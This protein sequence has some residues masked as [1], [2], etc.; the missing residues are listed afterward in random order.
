MSKELVQR[1]KEQ[2]KASKDLIQVGMQQLQRGLSYMLVNVGFCWFQTMKKMESTQEEFEKEKKA[3]EELKTQ[4]ESVKKQLEQ[5]EKV[6]FNDQALHFHHFSIACLACVTGGGLRE[7]TGEEGNQGPPSLPFPPRFTTQAHYSF[8]QSFFV[9]FSRLLIDP[10]IQFNP[11]QILHPFILFSSIHSPI[12][13]RE[14]SFHCLVLQSA[15]QQSMMSLEIAEYERTLESLQSKLDERVQQLQ[16][17]QDE[18]D[19]QEKRV[20]DYKMQVGENVV[21]VFL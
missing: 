17:A 12:H 20:E 21:Y 11:S 6:H 16:D 4:L 2:E 3:H 1:E 19:R 5:A 14:G 9:L 10:C 13:L 15:T 18:I 8:N 7:K